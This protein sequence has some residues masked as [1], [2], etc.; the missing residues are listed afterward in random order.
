MVQVSTKK[1]VDRWS[2]SL[3]S[4]DLLLSSSEQYK[5]GDHLHTTLY[6]PFFLVLSAP[7]WYYVSR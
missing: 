6:L 2:Q 5:T 1:C 7:N 3:L 4:R